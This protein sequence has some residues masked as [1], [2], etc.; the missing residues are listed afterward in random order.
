[1]NPIVVHSGPDYPR[2]YQH[3]YPFDIFIPFRNGWV[4]GGCS[5]GY[6]RLR[7]R[8]A[9]L[10][11]PNRSSPCSFWLG[12]VTHRTLPSC[13]ESGPQGHSYRYL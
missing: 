7:S 12:S 6:E 2:E 4:I 8:R 11:V 9:P 1:M 5:H 13:F 3:K 10:R